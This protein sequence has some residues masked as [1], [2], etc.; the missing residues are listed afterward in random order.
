[1][2]GHIRQRSP[3]RWAIVLDLTDPATGERRRKWHSFRGTK[4]E[5]QT[6]CARLIAAMSGG[7]YTEPAKLTLGEFLE[8]WLEHARSRVA[9]NTFD[10]YALLVRKNIT[11]MIGAV[12]LTK[13]RPEQIATALAAAQRTDGKG[14]LS[15]QTR[16]HMH[17]VLKRA[18]KQAVRW[19]KLTHNPLDDL[20]APRVEK[21]TRATYD[22]AAAVAML[23]AARSRRV[24][25]PCPA[26]NHV[27]LAPW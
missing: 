25:V 12:V 10:R 26:G 4:R 24:F 15:A 13:L 8:T 7:S 14:G 9:P 16:L 19:K 27:R 6:E 21:K 2:K 22:M 23:D 20:D 5:A 3:G 17:R 11:P 1:M 18:L